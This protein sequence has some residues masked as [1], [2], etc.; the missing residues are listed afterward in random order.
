MIGGIGAFSWKSCDSDH[1]GEGTRIQKTVFARNFGMVSP[2]GYRKSLRL[3]KQA[4][5]FK[6]PDDLFCGYS[7]S[8]SAGSEA[9]ER[10]Q[11]QS[12]CRKHLSEIIC[13]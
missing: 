6:R 1:P 11:G 7:G 2:E 10:G 8:M 3:M 13:S 5:K 9:E 4:E 12:D